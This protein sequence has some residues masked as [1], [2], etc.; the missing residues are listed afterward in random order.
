LLLNIKEAEYA[1]DYKVVLQFDNG[2][3]KIVDLKKTIFND[4]RAV[5]EPLR[6]KE[7]FKDFHVKFN[8]ITWKNEADFAPEFLYAIGKQF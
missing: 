8:T 7:F 2:V 1:G 4:H 6:Q 3:K 5:F